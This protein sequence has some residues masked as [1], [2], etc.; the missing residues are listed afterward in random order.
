VKLRVISLLAV[1]AAVVGGGAA[2]SASA[3]IPRLSATGH[4]VVHPA[5]GPALSQLYSQNDNAAGAVFPSQNFGDRP[6]L[7]AQG[8][9]DFTVP[10]GF[11]WRVKGVTVTG[12]YYNC[13]PCGPA[14]SETVTFYKNTKTGHPGR[15]KNTQTVTGADSSGSFVIP[16]TGFTLPAGVYW[17]SVAANMNY[18]PGGQWGWET[19]S[20]LSGAYA[21]WRNPGGGWGSKCTT[22]RVMQTCL[23]A[24]TPGPDFM[25]SLTGRAITII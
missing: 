8:A 3:S 6:T 17:V 11:K 4:G 22:W 16:L 19:R 18:S 14:T 5:S 7:S 9:D 24:A 2:A 21:R 12:Q 1:S 23:K 13:A 20:V 25:Y 10:T 15:V